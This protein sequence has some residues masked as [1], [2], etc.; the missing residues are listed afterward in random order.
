[1]VAGASLQDH[2]YLGRSV[3]TASLVLSTGMGHVYND[4]GYHTYRHRLQQQLQH[5]RW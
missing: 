3:Q 5:R 4:R 2:P 1:M